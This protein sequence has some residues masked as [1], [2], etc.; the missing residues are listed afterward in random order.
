VVCGGGRAIRLRRK[1]PDPGNDATY[2]AL[3][4][5]VGRRV[6][7]NSGWL[8]GPGGK[9]YRTAARDLDRA[10]DEAR[11]Y[12]RMPERAEVGMHPAVPRSAWTRN[13]W[14]A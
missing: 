11:E 8:P 10:I 6:A 4:R 14:R 5:R 2:C 12:Q 13:Y 9:P 1:R 3:G 7:P